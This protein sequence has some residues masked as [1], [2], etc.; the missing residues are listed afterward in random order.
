[1]PERLL[2]AE[3]AQAA[4][5]K[6]IQLPHAKADALELQGQNASRTEDQWT[7]PAW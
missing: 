1:M 2:R 6:P 7:V 3:A 5:A 4:A